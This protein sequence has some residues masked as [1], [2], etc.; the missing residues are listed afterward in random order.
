MDALTKER[1]SHSV[2][3]CFL[4]YYIF[5]HSTYQ[6]A[7]LALVLLSLFFPVSLDECSLPWSFFR[8]MFEISQHEK[9]KKL[10]ID[11]VISW[12]LLEFSPLLFGIWILLEMQQMM[13][14]CTRWGNLES[15]GG[16]NNQVNVPRLFRLW[17]KKSSRVFLTDSTAG[18]KVPWEGTSLK[19]PWT[20][21]G[22]AWG[23][24][25]SQCI[26]NKAMRLL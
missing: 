11:V 13:G 22:L 26:E 7:F 15:L 20:K 3:T 9:N 10:I 23:Q 1:N 24:G 6:S 18:M 14:N 2:D 4:L 8:L 12:D 21:L 17:L 5:N 16:G 25:N 19:T